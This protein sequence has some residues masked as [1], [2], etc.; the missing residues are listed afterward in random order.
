MVDCWKWNIVQSIY[1]LDRHGFKI[2][3]YECARNRIDLFL[4][5]TKYELLR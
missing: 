2:T 4:K 5:Y 1:L 3:F